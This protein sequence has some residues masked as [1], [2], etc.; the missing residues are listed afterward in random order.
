MEI[1]K[2]N[3][4]KEGLKF[5]YVN[6]TKG[7]FGKDSIFILVSFDVRENWVNGYVE[8]SRYLRLVVDNGKIEH[9]A[10]CGNGINFR[11]CK[12]KDI[13]DV[14]KKLNKYYEGSKNLFEYHAGELK[15]VLPN[16]A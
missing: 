3:K 2:I 1:D 6:V 9:F 8:N 13:D 16:V 4:I 10:G 7:F 11:K 5:P 14:I 12:Y 15:G